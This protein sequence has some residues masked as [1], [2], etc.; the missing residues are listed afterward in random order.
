MADQLDPDAEVAGIVAVA[1]VVLELLGALL[2]EPGQLLPQRRRRQRPLHLP[3]ASSEQRAGADQSI[4]RPTKEAIGAGSGRKGSGG[5]WRRTGAMGGGGRSRSSSGC[6]PPPRRGAPCPAL[7]LR[8][9]PCLR[10]D[11]SGGR[12]AGNPDLDGLNDDGRPAAGIDIIRICVRDI[13]CSCYYVT[14]RT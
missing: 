2:E 13:A 5:W 1:C 3:H 12:P 6:R 8:R 11:L 10:F 4:D 9:R 7:R 14:A